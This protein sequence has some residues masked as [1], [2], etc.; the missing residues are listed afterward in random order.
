[1]TMRLR[2]QTFQITSGVL[3]QSLASVL[4]EKQRRVLI[5]AGIWIRA[6]S[7]AFRPYK[8]TKDEDFAEG[9]DKTR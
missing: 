8:S 7:P 5:A 6:Q 3:S 1:M 9:R 4:Q 2:V